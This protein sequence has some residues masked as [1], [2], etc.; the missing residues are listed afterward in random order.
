MTSEELYD[1]LQHTYFDNVDAANPAGAVLAFTPDMHWQH[2]QVW[3]HDGHDSRRTDR[4][5][6]RNALLDFMEARVKEMQII[7]I[8]HRVD[9]VIVTGDRG[10]F[11][12]SVLDPT[13]RTL[14]FLGWVEMRNGLI[15]RYIVVPEDFAA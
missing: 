7:Q 3:A 11:R 15:Q 13:G 8:R 5:Y 1:H 12:A 6:G 10:A 9:E 4:L 2:T 14:G